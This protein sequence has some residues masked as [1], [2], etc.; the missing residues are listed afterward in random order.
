MQ[1]ELSK[2][3]SILLLV[4]VRIFINDLRARVCVCVC[5]TGCVCEKK[6]CTRQFVDVF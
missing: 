4:N 2:E 3:E 1:C 5:V 6:N